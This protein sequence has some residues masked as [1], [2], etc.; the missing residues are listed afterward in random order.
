MTLQVEF[1]LLHF[2]CS[3][4]NEIIFG[5]VCS[6]LW[7]AST[8]KG[9]PIHFPLED[10]LN[11]SNTHEYSEGFQVAEFSDCR[12]IKKTW[13]LSLPACGR[14]CFSDGKFEASFL[15]V[16]LPSLWAWPEKLVALFSFVLFSAEPCC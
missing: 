9:L 4:V 14:I 16:T 15:Q 2:L 12:E 10:C 8:R 1:K 6:L 3:Q 7:S 5:T 13:S 11:R